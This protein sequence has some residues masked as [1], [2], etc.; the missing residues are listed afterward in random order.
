MSVI[1][2]FETLLAQGQDNALLRFGLGNAYLQAGQPDRAIAHLQATLGHDPGYSAAYK[3]L[4]KAFAESGDTGQAAET[5]R[6]GIEI[7]EQ[8]GDKQAAKEMTV[9]LKRLN[10]DKP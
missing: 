3:A 4:G 2:R 10:R 6:K 9:F 8:K 7:A 1:D 5:Y